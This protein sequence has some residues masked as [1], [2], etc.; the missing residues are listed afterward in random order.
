[1]IKIVKW[2]EHTKNKWNKQ[3]VS[4][5]KRSINMWDNG[6]RKDIIPFFNTY[7]E[8][9]TSVLDIGC[10]SG[11]GTYKLKELAYEVTGIDISEKMVQLAKNHLGNDVPLYVGSVDDLPFNDEAFDHALLIN[12]IEWTEHPI[13][14]LLE[15]KRILKQGGMLCAG[16]LGATSGPRQ[17]SYARLYNE[18]VVMNTMM[19]WE[20]FQL[21]KE[22]GFRLIAQHAIHK[23][24]INEEDVAHLPDDLKQAVSFMTLFML[25][26][27]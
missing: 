2:N 15:I 12:V 11:Y 24:E 23:H 27:E 22:N 3:A 10:G 26:K 14:A 17:N 8:Q 6:S 21:A 13:D 4:W 7:V 25:E 20:F 19:P 16:I 9:A 5:D 18:D 1:M